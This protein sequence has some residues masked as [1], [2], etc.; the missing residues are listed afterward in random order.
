MGLK[1]NSQLPMD[2]NLVPPATI[3]ECHSVL[4]LPSLV[5]VSCFGLSARAR[6]Q[7]TPHVEIEGGMQLP[8]GIVPVREPSNFPRQV[9]NVTTRDLDPVEAAIGARVFVV[10]RFNVRT[11]YA[12]SGTTTTTTISC[13]CGCQDEQREASY[14]IRS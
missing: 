5:L 3:C 8:T 2:V 9:P 14:S 13:F 10:K 4:S 12:W 11:P 6:A 1:L 7:T